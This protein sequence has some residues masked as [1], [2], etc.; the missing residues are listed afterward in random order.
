MGIG[1]TWSVVRKQDSWGDWFEE[2]WFFYFKISEW[3][4]SVCWR[5]RI[6]KYDGPYF[7]FIFGFFTF[8]IGKYLEW[9]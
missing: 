4:P 6:V 3:S 8:Q 1:T 9:D 2:G 5:C 7:L